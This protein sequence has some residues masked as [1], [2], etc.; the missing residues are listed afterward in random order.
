MKKIFFLLVLMGSISRLSAQTEQSSCYSQWAKAFELRG[1][2]EVKDGWHEGVVL[3]IRTGSQTKC[4]TAKVQ[5]KDGHVKDIFIK[6]VDGKFEIYS[7]EW[8]YTDQQA[9]V[10]N[11][12][13]K[14]LQTMADDLVNVIFINHL[15]PKKKAFELAPLP[16]IDDF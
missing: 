12:I 6:Y 2:D 8:K 4:Y 10:T 15:K 16:D 5:V 14:T 11:G 13:T 3:S 1:S 7:P 9:K